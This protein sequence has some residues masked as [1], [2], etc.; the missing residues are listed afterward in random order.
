[1]VYFRHYV[2]L[3]SLLLF[4]PLLACGPKEPAVITL[5]NDVAKVAGDFLVH[6]KAGDEAKAALT[7]LASARDE[8]HEGFASDH[9][10]LKALPLLTPRFITKKPRHMIGPE[11]TE[12]T[13]IYAA[14]QKGQW[15][16]AELRLYRLPDEAF[17][18]DHWQ[19][20]NRA[21]VAKNYA[22]PDAEIMR[23]MVP[24]MLWGMGGLALFSLIGLAFF[25]WVVKR[26]PAMV[27]PEI[28]VEQRA[29]AIT[30]REQGDVT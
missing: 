5:P 10:K 23:E 3:F 6:V 20:S 26:R 2:G 30:T 18:I 29:A 12:Y 13:V 8:L 28:P 22:G 15:T 16:T 1:L 7:V 19:I 11:D 25:I 24:G 4:L 21:P 14:K 27:A 17:E 9:A